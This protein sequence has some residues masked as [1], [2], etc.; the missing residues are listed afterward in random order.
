VKAAFDV[1]R[2]ERGHQ[3]QL[4]LARLG[5]NHHLRLAV[6]DRRLEAHQGAYALWRDLLGAMH[7]PDLQDHVY[8]CQ[9]WLKTH[10]LYLSADA[11]T[12]FRDAYLAALEQRDLKKQPDRDVKLLNETWDRIKAA[13]PAIERGLALPATTEADTDT[14]PPPGP[15][16]IVERA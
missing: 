11:R 1:E 12:A 4:V 16:T 14:V 2:Q 10:S 5:F 15:P 6:L 13:G 9:E 3:H 8:E 7:S